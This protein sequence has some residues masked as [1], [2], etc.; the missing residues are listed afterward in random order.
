[1]PVR[2]GDN[3]HAVAAALQHPA[4]YSRRKAGMIYIGIAID[5]YKIQ[6]VPAAPFHIGPAG[7]QKFL[8]HMF[9]LL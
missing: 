2:L 6:L 5:I 8:V 7:H 4:D 1:M 3:P 9:P